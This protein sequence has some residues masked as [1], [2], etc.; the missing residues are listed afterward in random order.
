[1]RQFFQAPTTYVLFDW[2]DFFYYSSLLSGGL[3]IFS[4][5]EVYCVMSM[6]SK[7]DSGIGMISKTVFAYSEFACHVG[8][9]LILPLIFWMVDYF[10][11]K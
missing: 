6:D 7:E 5:I 8:Y 10:Y 11:C 9:V 2:K 1:M 3:N 4:S